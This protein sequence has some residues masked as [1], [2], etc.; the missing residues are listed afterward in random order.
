MLHKR[1]TEE[2]FPV[3]IFLKILNNHETEQVP[4]I[5]LDTGNKI[6]QLLFMSLC[7]DAS[8]LLSERM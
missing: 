8:E 7:C 3:A 6:T 5:P 2:I 1:F 4:A